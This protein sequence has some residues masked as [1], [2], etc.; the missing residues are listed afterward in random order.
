MFSF[1][2]AQA[3]QDEMIVTDGLSDSQT[4]IPKPNLSDIDNIKKV[5]TV[6]TKTT[7][8]TRTRTTPTTTSTKQQQ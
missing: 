7:T 5:R 6:A 8:R 1:L 3:S 2:D 4:D